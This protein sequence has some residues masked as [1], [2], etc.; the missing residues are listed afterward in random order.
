MSDYVLDASVMIKWAVPENAEEDTDKALGL[1]A[2]FEQGHI[3]L[4]QPIHWLCEVG[5][6]LCRISQG[7][8]DG[9][10]VCP[11]G[12]RRIRWAGKKPVLSKS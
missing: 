3:N 11:L 8:A 6:V 12:I 1:L 4:L 7:W 10:I 2:D 5:A 9:S